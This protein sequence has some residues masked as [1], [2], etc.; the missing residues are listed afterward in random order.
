MEI[1]P[2]VLC[3]PNVIFIFPTPDRINPPMLKLDEAVIGYSEEK[4]I[5][6]RVNMSID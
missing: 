2:E 1:V 6:N 4:P 5:I 3:D